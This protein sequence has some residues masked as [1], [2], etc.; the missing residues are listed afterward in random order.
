MSAPDQQLIT[1]LLEQQKSSAYAQQLSQEPQENAL[2]ITR[3][4]TAKYKVYVIILLILG[5]FLGTKYLPEGF[6]YYQ[7]IQAQKGEKSDQLQ[8]LKLKTEQLTQ[9]KLQL[10]NLQQYQEQLLHCVNE[11]KNC[12]ELPDLLKKDKN[13]A[14]AY[15]QMGSLRSEKMTIDEQKILKNLDQYLIKNNPGEKGSSANGVIEGIEIGEPEALEGMEGFFRLPLV[16]KVTFSDK[17]DLI[18]FVDNIENFI[19]PEAKDRI[20]YQIEEVSYDMMAY[21]EAQTTDITLSAYY[22]N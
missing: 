22:F 14:I 1:N 7:V 17:D 13:A 4:V 3:V 9:D 19:I 11:Q 16:L 10:L 5:V 8:E 2:A 15:L 12:S 18:S 21:D 20:L 6:E